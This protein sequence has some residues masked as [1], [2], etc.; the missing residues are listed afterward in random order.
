[1]RYARRLTI[2][3]T[4]VLAVCGIGSATALGAL[5]EFVPGPPAGIESLVKATKF[6]TVGKAVVKCKKGNDSG[7]VTGAKTISLKIHLVECSIPGALCTS[8]GAAPGEII[9]STL[10]G[11]LGYI[12]KKS[13]AVGLDLTSLSGAFTVFM[14]GATPFEAIGS[15]IGR[16]KPVNKVVTPGEFFKVKFSQKAGIQKPENF[17]AEPPD[18]LSTSISGKPFEQTG[19]AAT[20]ELLITGEEIK[21]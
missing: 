6:E 11:T 7:E 1:M 12:E 17:E 14:C 21:A 2:V 18:V 9:T 16:I 4:I 15:V 10:T 13:K 19:L 3:S 8:P 20:D 5:P